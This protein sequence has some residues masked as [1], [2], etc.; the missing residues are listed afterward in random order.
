MNRKRFFILLLYLVLLLPLVV[1]GAIQALQTNA[2]SPIDWVSAEFPAKRVYAEF[3]QQFGPGDVV[4]MSWPGCTVDEARLD[5]LMVSLRQ[6]KAF[7]SPELEPYFERVACGREEV[8]KL[9]ADPMFL[10]E[11]EAR[12]RLQGA[13][14]GSDGHQTCV[15]VT[16]NE[17]GLADRSRIVPLL[18]RA[19][20]K[21]CGARPGELRL[22]GPVIDG[23][24]VDDASQRSM[25]A[26]APLSNVVVLVLC[27]LC[28]DSVPAALLVFGVSVFCQGLTLAIIHYCGDKMSAL[29]IVMPPLIQVLAVAGG[30]H[31]VNYYF[32][33][34]RGSGQRGAVDRALR[35]GWLPCAL[36]SATTAIGLGSLLVSGLLP[37][38][39]FGGYAAIG[40]LVTLAVLLTIIPGALQLRP[41]APPALPAD[42]GR[43]KW[44]RLVDWL[45]GRHLAVA[46]GAVALMAVMTIGAARINT[47]V[48]IETLF[49]PQSPILQDYAW[50]EQ[51]IGPLVPIEVVLTYDS[52]SS[53]PLPERLRLVHDVDAAIK[54]MPRVGS[55]LSAVDFLPP[56][57]A[58]P[59]VPESPEEAGLQQAMLEASQE[60]VVAANYLHTTGRHE[61]WRVTGFVSA[62]D[63]VDYGRFLED[64]RAKVEPLLP[65]GGAGPNGV[66]A[67]YTGI[68][69]LVHEI[70]RQLLRDL[71]V[72]F[73]SAFV[74]IA[75]VMTLVQAG[76]LAGLA[77]MI[78]NVFPTLLLFGAL[79]WI[80][81]PMDIG[82]VMTASVALGIAVDD[83]LHF[84]TFFRNQL[85]AGRSR[86]DAVLEACRHCGKAMM[87][88]TL[89]CG[90]G[91]MT[92]SYAEFLPT[93]R[94]AWM[95]MALLVIALAGD[96]IVLPALLLGPVGRLFEGSSSPAGH[97]PAPAVGAP[98]PA[99]QSVPK[100][101]TTS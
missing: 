41:I 100:E 28:L 83:T 71:F 59:H 31:L 39:A 69:P 49:Q 36:S 13:L 79:G 76:F 55:V 87:H 10:S 74:V 25:K 12:A 27:W 47:S 75:I 20:V 35:M 95:M 70:Q 4:V 32:D 66:T 72:S 22:A 46:L 6:S 50:L 73:L 15:V 26:F 98:R 61:H 80:Q 5:P 88:T 84:L 42:G 90:L 91:M 85:A 43:L 54:A 58:D 92:L 3:R 94:F 51:Q 81:F 2:N 9:T 64:V 30:I 7:H 34:A 44:E 48:R 53:R 67:A 24:T 78:P 60:A 38:R 62:L 37:V 86:R 45:H 82:S 63:D 21:F 14:L 56:E 17:L 40:V 52:R 23:L 33:T 77:A 19:A 29:L 57:L 16:F 99:A 89:I 11:T 65:A 8:L 101:L 68:M 1:S 93:A 18:K 97:L 96:L